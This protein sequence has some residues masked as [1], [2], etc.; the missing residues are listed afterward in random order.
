MAATTHH[1]RGLPPYAAL[2]EAVRLLAE[3]RNSLPAGAGSTVAR[4]R[5][6]LAESLARVDA[7]FRLNLRVA[8]VRQGP[9]GVLAYLLHESER[10]GRLARAM[11]RTP[12]VS[13]AQ[14]AAL[15]SLAF[16]RHT[17]QEVSR[18]SRRSAPA[19]HA[20]GRTTVFDRLPFESTRGLVPVALSMSRVQTP[21]ARWERLRRAEESGL[22]TVAEEEITGP[23]EHDH[24]VESFVRHTQDRQGWAAPLWPDAAV[25]PVPSASQEK[26][27]ID[28]LEAEAARAAGVD[29]AQLAAVRARF[30]T[31]DPSLTS[32]D[33]RLLR[34]AA[35]ALERHAAA[36]VRGRPDSRAA[37]LVDVHVTRAREEA[38]R[39]TTRVAAD[40]LKAC[41]TARA[42]L[43]LREA[44]RAA[45]REVRAALP[46]GRPQPMCEV[47][48]LQHV[49]EQVG[50]A[51]HGIAHS[52]Q[53]KRM[54]L[55]AP[56]VADSTA[57][58]ALQRLDEAFG[59]TCVLLGGTDDAAVRIPP[60]SQFGIRMRRARSCDCGRHPAGPDAGGDE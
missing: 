14:E 55:L 44:S 17:A 10:L 33:L 47:D 53:S 58:T 24:D 4:L 7:A 20:G 50:Q 52:V 12:G 39:L 27:V 15:L 48:Y 28:A 43:D 40:A 35:A 34:R 1:V 29:V 45:A 59:A 16:L 41:N 18:I 30:E 42:S 2:T 31:G 11:P 3:D 25:P 32:E 60:P 21:K 13:P 56:P 57:R 6:A 49:R 37:H 22:L 8:P 26:D 36:T 54:V 46:G 5:E 19:P 51:L 38:P 23:A 9:A